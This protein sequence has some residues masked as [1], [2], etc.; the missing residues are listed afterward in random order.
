V[1]VCVCAYEQMGTTAIGATAGAGHVDVI[2]VLA[3]LGGDVNAHSE[4]VN[5]TS[6]CVVTAQL[7]L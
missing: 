7:S 6:T 5:L 3:E 2:H 1:C 4:L